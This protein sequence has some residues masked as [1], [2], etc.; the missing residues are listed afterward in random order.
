M[1]RLQEAAAVIAGVLHGSDCDLTHVHTDTRALREGALFVA[2]RGDHFDGH[3][4]LL[5]AQQAGA[6]AA[7]VQSYNEQIALPQVVVSDTVMALGLLARHVR[8]QF[9][10]PVIAL[11][12]SSGK[13]T[14][15]GL[16]RAILAEVGQVHATPGNW[17]NHIGVP[18]TLFGLRDQDYGVIE[19]GT[20]QVGEISYLTELAEPDVALVN[21]IGPAHYAGFGS[22]EA[23]ARE[24]SAIYSR[25]QSE[26]TAVVNLNDAFAP[27]M[28][29]QTSFCRQLGFGIAAPSQLPETITASDITANEHACAHFTLHLPSGCWP[30]QLQVAGQHNVNNALA[31]ATCAYAVGV[32]GPAIAAGLGKFTGEKGR[33]QWLQA[34]SGAQVI[35]DT[36]NANPES[37][38][39]AIRCL[40]GQ[41]SP[42]FLVFGDMGE[43]GD[44]AEA[45]HRDIGSFAKQAGITYLFCVGACS[46]F[47]AAAFGEGAQYFADHCALITALKK[48]VT[49]NATLLVKGSRSARM[50]QVVHALTAGEAT[51]C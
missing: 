19:I 48:S 23:I 30:V 42:T 39:A 15:K 38:K 2:L 46:R 45:A 13:T 27:F 5:A 41:A 47:A 25:L 31:A 18:L 40:Q 26:H 36:Y 9:R 22:V 37:V 7:V 43:L 35:D 14:V 51:S 4:F 10:G 16:L 32:A 20:S 17:N 29:Q 34:S 6:V 3:D 8:R 44:F 33:L 24:K 21:N 50:E 11:T 12:G 49:A 28:L 1:M